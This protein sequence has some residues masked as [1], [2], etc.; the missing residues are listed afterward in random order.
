MQKQQIRIFILCILIL[1]FVVS[2]DAQQSPKIPETPSGKILTYL[3]DAFN[4]G[5]EEQ[6][7]NFIRDHWKE[8]EGMFERRLEFFKQVYSDAGGVDLYRIEDYEDYSISALLQ[9]KKPTG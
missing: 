9:A 6:W 8:K 5:D 2:T 1:I 3:L 7:K 4:S